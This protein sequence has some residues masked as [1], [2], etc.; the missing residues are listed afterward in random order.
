MK[1]APKK[2]TLQ[3]ETLNR[4]QLEEVSGGLPTGRPYS[5]PECANTFPITLCDCD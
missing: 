1:K 3:R 4:L 2:L 5:C